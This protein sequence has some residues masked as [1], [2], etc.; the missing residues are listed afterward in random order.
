MIDLGLVVARLLH[1]AA[2]TTLAGVSF[3]PLY[4]CADA[5]PTALLRWRQRVLL[6]AA[7]VSLLSGV[8]WFVFAV[9]N[10][11]GTLADV[12]DREVLWMILNEMT[13]GRVWTAR[14]VLSII[15][16]GLFWK[17]VVSKFSPRRDLIT[18]FLTT[19]MLISLAGV[20]PSPNQEGI[21]GVIH[22]VSG[23]GH[24]PCGR[25]AAGGLV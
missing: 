12:G 2:Q 10:M 9:A 23:A 6:A 4:A 24:L 8:L 16:V 3:F 13:F 1:Y 11:S 17:R 5:E 15:M 18:L 19:A 25:A 7:I 14:L 20:G 21:E 22:L